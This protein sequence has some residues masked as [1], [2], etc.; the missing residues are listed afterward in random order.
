MSADKSKDSAD[1]NKPA[2]PKAVAAKPAAPKPVA[3]NVIVPPLFRKIDW[4]ALLIAFGAVWLVYF[5]TL[6]PELTLEDSGELCT[7]SFYAGIPHPPGYPFWAIYS[8]LWT[9]L[10][11]VGN[12]AWRVE[13]GESTAAAFACGLVAL[14]VS[15]GSSMLMEGIEELKSLTG[16]WETVICLVSGATAGILLGLG[17][18]MWSESVAINRISLF[19]VPWVMLVLAC[20]MR[21]LYAPKQLRFLFVAMFVFGICLTIHQTLLVAAFGIEAA[22][23]YAHRR[24]GRTFFFGNSVIFLGGLIAKM[25]H[26]TA[27]LD[28]AQMLLVIYFAVGVASIACY[29]WFAILTRETFDEFLADAGLAAFILFGVLAASMGLIFALLSIAGLGLFA[30]QIWKTRKLGL[31]W[32]IASA[33]L[34]LWLLGAAFY[35][36]E[37][38]SGMTNP[39]MEWGYPRTVDGFWHALS[40]GQYEKANPTDL[41][42]PGGME[43]FGNQ[44]WFLVY[45]I[46]DEYN[47][48]LLFV[49]LIPFL[50]FFKLQKRERSWI[51]CLGVTYLCISVLL[52]IIMNPGDDRAS[53]DLHR[54]FFTSSH[55]VIAILFGYGLALTAAY[56]A[57]HY[58]TFRRWGLAGGS[59][60]ALMAIYS[61]W[62]ATGKHYFGLD[63]T[64]SL[65]DLPHYIA[66]AF[67]PN[68]GGLPIIGT[69][70]LVALPFAFLAALLVYRQRAPLA[71]T[72]GLFAAMPIYSG[73][74][75]WGTSEQRN[76][77]FGYWFGH[78]MFTPP[79]GIY[80]EMTR[81]AVLFGGTDPGRFCPT[82]MIFCESFIP[83]KDQPLED[84]KFDR[85]DVYII[86]QN[87]LADPTYLEYI[88]AQY[89]RSTQIDPPFFQELLRSD[90]EKEQNY[91]TNFVARLAYQFLDRPLTDF[92]AKVEARRRAEGVYPPK[93][94]YTP[95]PDDS[96]MC[97]SEYMQDAQQRLDHDLRFPNEPKLIKSGE[98]VHMNPGDNRVS[99]SGQVAVMSIN[100]LLTKVIFDRNPSNEFFVEESF[101]LDWMYPY[102]SP[103]GIIMKINRQPL[104]E[105]T[106]D[107]IDKDHRFWSRYSERMIGNWVT[108]D[109][110]LKDVAAFVEK[111]YLGKDFTGFTGDRKFIRDDEAQKSFSKLRS[112]I[113]G[114]YDYRFH[115]AKNATEQQAMLKEADFAYKQSFAFCPFS[116]EAV[117][118]YIILLT[119]V[120]RMDD[121]IIVAETCVKLD[122]NN[123]QMTQLLRQL[124]EAK[125]HPNVPG[126]Q[127]QGQGQ[128]QTVNLAQLQKAYKDNTNDFQ[129]AFNLAGAYLQLHQQ[130]DGMR[131]LDEVLTNPQVNAGAILFLAQAYAKFNN[132]PKLETALEKLT[133]LQPHSPEA[134]CDL[135]AMKTALRK[136]PDALTDLRVA[137]D[138]NAKRRA[139]DPKATDLMPVVRSDPR[140]NALHGTPEYE[141][142]IG[143]KK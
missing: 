16:K 35:F 128:T 6:A 113:G 52:V 19:G 112:S 79:Y 122:P 27:A 64:V 110:P 105:I 95:T 123:G 17:G 12:I 103:Y 20:M 55:G 63:G 29:I 58:Q 3:A 101:P 56:M 33:C 73:L 4:L 9:V 24:L 126:P 37:P 125:G 131:V 48:L 98:D 21:W 116:P 135:A 22:V 81:D 87:A 76:H 5:R 94:I 70:I 61:L 66:R 82:Y 92:G 100:G 86:T 132:L 133:V 142:L 124:R 13:V 78:D 41:F 53:V 83:H 25:T 115:H 141:Q 102:E 74:A 143:N 111:V 106:A 46:A 26:V 57:T 43:R 99:V 69:L 23:A 96:S 47:W 28:T 108:Y 75:H 36:Y 65:S 18:T 121:A 51:T 1:K 50:F 130:E 34:L 88:R 136:T 14:M 62:D 59:I 72:L 54:V 137:L 44:L 119:S 114:I 68:Q 38:I 117:Y 49:T 129:A 91:S 40:R 139:A 11:P 97:F 45:G 127:G 85:R 118:R 104:D 30:Y 60:A 7:G 31:E 84:Q 89:N 80:P 71:I 107:M 138:E 39:P 90:K 134:W 67:Q 93:E 77:W 2:A 120:G 42:A 8:W 10:L 140:F 109:T 32:L 15:R